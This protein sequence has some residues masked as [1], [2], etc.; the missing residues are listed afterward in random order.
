[1][2]DPIS[3][4][5]KR[6]N[7]LDDLAEHLVAWGCPPDTTPSR[8]AVLLA[9]AEQHGWLLPTVDAPPFRGRGSTDEGRARARRSF[10]Q[11]RAGCR[12]TALGDPPSEHDNDCPVFIEL[13][14]A[15]S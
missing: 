12:C 7:L 13:E 9:L 6:Q 3:R 2:T 10:E 11:A 5:A 15:T 1:M 14:A 8:A 4:A